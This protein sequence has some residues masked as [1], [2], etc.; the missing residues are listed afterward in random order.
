MEGSGELK[1]MKGS[2]HVM[3]HRSNIGNSWHAPS[4]EIWNIR[5]QHETWNTRNSTQRKSG[6][7]AH[8]SPSD[9]SNGAQV[10]LTDQSLRWDPL[11]LDLPELKSQ[12]ATMQS[13][14]PETKAQGR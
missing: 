14:P 5:K 8:L 2:G 12:Q 6:Q 13:I 1:G 7:T 10:I 4:H 3:D 9:D 11:T